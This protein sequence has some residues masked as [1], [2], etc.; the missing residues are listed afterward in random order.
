MATRTHVGE[1]ELPCAVGHR[2]LAVLGPDV[3]SRETHLA[4]ALDAVAVRVNPHL[5]DCGACLHRRGAAHLHP[6]D[7]FGGD[8]IVDTGTPAGDRAALSY[9]A[10]SRCQGQDVADRAGR[11]GGEGS[12]RE[13]DE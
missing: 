2:H 11:P 1:R 6:D 12:G 13:E 10:R 4:R 9:R 7:R 5:A 3:D 8:G